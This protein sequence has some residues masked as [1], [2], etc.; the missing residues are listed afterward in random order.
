MP[1]PEI[2]SGICDA[3]T[4]V[5]RRFILMLLLP[6]YGN[7]KREMSESFVT[8][9]LST[10]LE[11]ARSRSKP[12]IANLASFPYRHC[13]SPRRGLEEARVPLDLALHCR[14]HGETWRRQAKR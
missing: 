9:K 12:V 3:K 1:F 11:L 5:P 7:C 14:M 8:S 6:V 4:D 10:V 2:D 13:C